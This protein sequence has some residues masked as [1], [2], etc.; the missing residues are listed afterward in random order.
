MLVFRA[1][2]ETLVKAP[3]DVVFG[4]VG[5]ISRHPELAGSGEVLRIRKLTEGPVGVGARFEADEDI[6]VGNGRQKFVATSTVV[7]YDPPRVISWI[8]VPPIRPTPRRIQ[9]WFRLTPEGAGTRVVHEV[10]VDLGGLLNL[11]MKLPYARMRGRY[12]AEGMDKTLANLRRLVEAS[13]VDNGSAVIPR[14]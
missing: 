11:V 2:K 14:V 8:P 9:W 7:E 5:D 12:V 13:I 1:R 4:L 10:E 6:R 3:P